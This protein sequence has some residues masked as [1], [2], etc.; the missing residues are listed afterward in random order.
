MRLP[1]PAS[2]ASVL[3]LTFSL[4]LPATA[5]VQNG[6]SRCAA[7]PVRGVIN[8]G[9]APSNDVATRSRTDRLRVQDAPPITSPY[10]PSD[11]NLDQ[12]EGGLFSPLT[13][14]SPSL[15]PTESAEPV[16][17]QKRQ[18]PPS[19]TPDQ[20]APT[21]PSIAD[22]IRQRYSDPRVLR[23][24]EQLTSQGTESFYAEVSQ[25]IDERHI[26]PASYAR[27]VNGALNHLSHALEV[28]AFI[29]AAQVQGSGEAVEKFRDD[30]ERIRSQAKVRSTS[31][32]IMVMRDVQKQAARSIKM[33]PSAVGLEFLYGATDSLDQFSMLLPPE[34]NGGPSVG[35]NENIVGIGVEI[36][37]HPKGLRIL[38]LLQGGPAEQADFR[39]GDVI[40]HVDGKDLKSLDLQQAVDLIVGPVGSPI[41]I[42]ASRGDRSGKVTLTR[43]K[44]VFHS[45]VDVRMEDENQGIGYL[46]L[47]QFADSTMDE[48]DAALLKLHKQGMKSLI[49][50]LRGNPGGLLT[51]SIALSDKFLPS[52]TIVET[53]GRTRADNSREVAQYANTWSVPLVVLIDHNSAS[54]SEIFAAAIQENHR[55]VIIGETSYGKGTVQTLFPLQ[56]VPAAL[57]LTTAKFYS[58][59]GREMAGAGVTPDF[60]VAT[61]STEDQ[62]QDEVLKE[63]I[64]QIQDFRTK[65]MAERLRRSSSTAPVTHV[66]A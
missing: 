42:Q 28:P 55:G 40:T 21:Q 59:D 53:R 35:L 60:K 16:A 17:T 48:I 52:G 63:G 14:S 66:A 18:P 8:R 54:A 44:I 12:E 36:E 47:E 30:L 6:C 43:Q 20:T 41:Q 25:L 45:V 64:R 2:I 11:P 5:Q 23:M 22:K 33:N 39:R 58:P 38:K 29:K 57:R 32:A 31:D 7:P 1:I 65:I 46:K 15:I 37:S 56:S 51:T 50:D 24:L 27:R 61:K 9:T 4:S 49:M 3:A 62:E 19:N 26:T 10:Y 34:K 13:R